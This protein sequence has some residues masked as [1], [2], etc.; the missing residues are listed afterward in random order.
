MGPMARFE[1]IIDVAHGPR[2]SRT[3]RARCAEAAY[4]AVRSGLIEAGVEPGARELSTV[5]RR[6]MLRRSPILLGSWDLGGFDDGSGDDGSAGVREPRR[7]KPAPPSLRLALIEPRQEPP[8][9]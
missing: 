4:Q 7:P 8:A 1:V 6:R 2:V 5:R 9:S 3:V